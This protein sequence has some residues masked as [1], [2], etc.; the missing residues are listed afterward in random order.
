M[1]PQVIPF[2]IFA[3][4]DFFFA[5]FLGA[6]FLTAFFAVF[7][8]G[9]FFLGAAFFVVFFA[10]AFFFFAIGI[11]LQVIESFLFN[12]H[13]LCL[14]TYSKS[15]NT[16]KLTFS[17]IKIIFNS[18]RKKNEFFLLTLLAARFEKRF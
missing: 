2:F 6:A 11:F 5:A 14:S 16:F 12:L 8:A 13:D 3:A 10:A 18:K 7:L 4:V 15:C 9:A 17:R 1:S